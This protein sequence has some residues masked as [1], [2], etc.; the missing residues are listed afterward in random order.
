MN[1]EENRLHHI[2]QRIVAACE[3]SGRNLEEITV[4]GASKTVSAERFSAFFAAG[5]R[6]V[7]ENYVQEALRKMSELSAMMEMTEP[8][9]S[10]R[11]DFASVRWHLIGALQSNK[12]REVVGR[13]SLIH[14]IDRTRLAQA[15]SKEAENARLRQ[16]VLL[17]VNIGGESGKAGCDVDELFD[18][19]EFCNDLPGVDVRGLMCLPPAHA[20]AEMSRPYFRHLRELRDALSQS[21]TQNGGSEISE[22]S[23]GMTND[24]E[25]AIEEGATIVRIGTGLF[26][27][28]R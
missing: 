28:R 5:L 7:G 23:M 8:S 25:V 3:R 22:L 18:L 14:S 15:L 13:F 16:A 2:R 4:V 9:S 24:Y 27:E 10:T 20:N 19:W 1:T 12:A 21:S 6:D 26:G 11:P 17:Q